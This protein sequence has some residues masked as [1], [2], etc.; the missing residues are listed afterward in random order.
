M[1]KYI[2]KY[3]REVEVTHVLKDGT[4]RDT[5]KGFELTKENCPQEFID[6]V[7]NM[8][9]GIGRMP[10]IYRGKKGL[11]ENLKKMREEEKKK[12]EEKELNESFEE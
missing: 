9:L 2:T 11:P 12:A 3:G 5:M 10:E 7:T 6:A 8:I 4:V 1:A